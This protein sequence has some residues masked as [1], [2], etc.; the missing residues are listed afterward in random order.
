MVYCNPLKK[1]FLIR[2]ILITFCVGRVW[3]VIR[4]FFFEQQA[5]NGLLKVIAYWYT[6]NFTQN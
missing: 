6:N 3:I 1:Q 4:Y 5:F 2:N